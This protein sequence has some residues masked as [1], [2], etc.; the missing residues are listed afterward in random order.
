VLGG[1]ALTGALV[2][3]WMKKT[4]LRAAGMVVGG[5]TPGGRTAPVGTAPRGLWSGLL[6]KLAGAYSVAEVI[7]K[8]AEYDKK[9]GKT[10]GIKQAVT[11]IIADAV[12]WGRDNK[13]WQDHDAVAA[14]NSTPLN[15]LPP[16]NRAE[17]RAGGMFDLPASKFEQVFE[18]AQT[19]LT[20]AGT[21]I[22]T[23]ITESGTAAGQSIL[24][25]AGR[26]GAIAGEA[27]AAA[28]RGAVGNIQVN[29][30]VTQPAVNP[31]RLGGPH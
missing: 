19:T 8:G 12:I 22:G 10:D 3:N 24:G 14:I 31:G 7:A 5:T 26:F 27:I 4:A 11:D 20:S 15:Q 9:T 25:T 23:A 1:T 18:T 2:M 17:M 21:Q 6:T 29:A 28:V 16:M 30:N 13:A